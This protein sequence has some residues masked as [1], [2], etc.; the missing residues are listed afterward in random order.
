MTK[1]NLFL[2]CMFY[3]Q[4]YFSQSIQSTTIIASKD[5]LIDN[6]SPTTNYGGIGSIEAGVKISGGVTTVRRSYLD[7]DLSGIPSNAI[8]TSATLSLRVIS[9]G[10][11]VTNSSFVLERANA[12][13]VETGTGSITWSNKPAVTTSDAISTS[14]VSSGWRNIT[15]TSHVQKMVESSVS[16]FGWSFRRSNE[17]T[18]TLGSTYRSNNYVV[19]ADRPK[20]VINY[21]IPF[22]V[23]LATINHES[24]V[25]SDD[26][27]ISVTVQ[28]GPS[29]PSYQWYTSADALITGATSSNLSN[30][31]SGWYG[32]K[33]SGTTGSPVYYSFIVGVK[34]QTI[35]VAYEPSHFYVDDAE[36]KNGSG[37]S[38]I[39]S[40]F[41]NSLDFKTDNFN[42]LSSWYQTKGLLKFRLWLDDAFIINSADLTLTGKNHDTSIRSNSSKLKKV[43]SDWSESSVCWFNAPYVS[44]VNAISLT[45]TSSSTQNRTVSMTN[46]WNDWKYNNLSNHGMLMELDLF[47]NTFTRMGFHSSDATSASQRPKINFILSLEDLSMCQPQTIDD[48]SYSELKYQ[49]DGG[50]TTT[51]DSKLKFSFLEEEAINS[52]NKIPYKI[53]DKNNV[54]LASSDLSGAT[55]GGAIAL[56]YNSHSNYKILDLGGVS[57]LTEG[58]FYTLEVTMINGQKKKLRFQFK[59]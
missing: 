42:V 18:A 11:D 16:S 37:R 38:D 12:S 39:N 41:G 29:S 43:T 31:S 9:E 45:S 55:T 4:I 23:S 58:E 21:Y 48:I 2:L 17:V 34:C 36:I 8:I 20:L 22:Y 57:S 53:F 46:F 6:Q 32:L 24:N 50:Y 59:Q 56:N 3:A 40:N 54:V 5:A 30:L 1:L 19:Q 26:G 25:N 35:N 44:S 10:S 14:S 27:S 7:F 28:G 47:N 13:W 33:I 49:I 15:V 52:G 51:F